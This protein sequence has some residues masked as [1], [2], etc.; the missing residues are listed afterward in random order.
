MLRAVRAPL[1][2]WALDE[3]RGLVLGNLRLI[4]RLLFAT[5]SFPEACSLRLEVSFHGCGGIGF[6]SPLAILAWYWL[7]LIF[8]SPLLIETMVMQSSTGQTSEQRLQPT[9]SSSRTLGIGLPGTRP[10]PSP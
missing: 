9:Q 7:Q 10:G 3:P 1:G 2:A 5:W 8:G 4:S 6:I